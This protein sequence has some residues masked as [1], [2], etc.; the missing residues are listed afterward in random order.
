MLEQE[1]QVDFHKN[2]V[3]YNSYQEKDNAL[4][5]IVM[6]CSQLGCSHNITIITNYYLTIIRNDNFQLVNPEKFFT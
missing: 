5:L 3:S 4:F 1:N 6:L 2:K